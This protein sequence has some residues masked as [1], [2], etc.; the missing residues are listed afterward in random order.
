MSLYTYLYIVIRREQM[1]FP[2]IK[3]KHF[4][5]RSCWFHKI[6]EYLNPTSQVREQADGK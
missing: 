1:S 4:S 6:D 3:Q 5:L 2:L